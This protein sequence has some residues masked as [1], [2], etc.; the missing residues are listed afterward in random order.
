MISQRLQ[1][2]LDAAA[3]RYQV[4]PHREAFTAQGVAAASH[5]SGWQMAKVLVGRDD[6]GYV[7][8]VL[9]ATC[10]LD[11]PSFRRIT[12]RRNLLLATEEE[13]RTVFPDCEVGAMPPYGLLY[14]MPVFMD[15]CF[16]RKGDM[17]FQPGN[18]HE[19]VRLGFD[20]FERTAHPVMTDFCRR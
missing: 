11:L 15:T 18:H 9:P 16:G 2:L 5:V 4:L 10:R 12:R 14:G 3:V 1:D 19:I 6:R 20:D 7:M 13:L 17:A 8:A